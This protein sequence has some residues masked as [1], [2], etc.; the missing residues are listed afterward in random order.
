MD[1]NRTH[2]KVDTRW[3]SES[4]C[5]QCRDVNGDMIE[6]EVLNY[7]DETA[8]KGDLASAKNIENNQ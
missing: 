3:P 7:M 2:T 8:S 6:A 4:Q 5:H 1:V